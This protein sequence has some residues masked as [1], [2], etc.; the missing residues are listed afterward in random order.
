MKILNLTLP[1]YPYMPVGNVWA[2]DS[3]FRMTPTMS[4]EK[5]GVEQYA[6]SFHSEAGTRLMLGACYDDEAPRI[7]DLDYTP[8]VNRET[9]VVDI[10]KEADEE[11]MPQDFDRALLDNP[12][13][14]DGDAVLIRTGWGRTDRYLEI[15]DDYARHTPHFSV[16]GAER[17]VEIMHARNTNLMLTDCAYVGNLGVGFMYGEWASREPWDRPPFPSDQAKAYM[18]HYTPERGAGGGAPDWAASL[19][20]HAGLTPVPALTNCDQIT[21]ARIR[22]TVLP[23][24]LDRAEGASCTV[25]A[26]ED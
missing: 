2:W 20:L 8:F 17:L 7:D 16:Q 19:P 13:F 15:G 11:L 6:M 10:P 25:F 21:S 23:L 24:M 1:L 5:H 14:H 4:L 12:D 22:V 18:R 3:P 26:F 9:V